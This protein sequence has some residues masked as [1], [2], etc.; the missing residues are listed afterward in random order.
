MHE[1]TNKESSVYGSLKD[2]ANKLK[3]PLENL[4]QMITDHHERDHLVRQSVHENA[5]FIKVHEGY[6]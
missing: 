2:F 1:F 3:I 4:E 5:A 6:P